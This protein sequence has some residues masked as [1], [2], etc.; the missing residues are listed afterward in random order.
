MNYPVAKC[1]RSSKIEHE[2]MVAGP[3]AKSSAY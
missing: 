1:F 3:S 2:A